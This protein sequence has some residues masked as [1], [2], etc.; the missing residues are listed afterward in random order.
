MPASYIYKVCTACSHSL[1]RAGLNSVADG[2]V[3]LRRASQ[4]VPEFGEHFLSVGAAATDASLYPSL[5]PGDYV[6]EPAVFQVSVMSYLYSVSGYQNQ[7]PLLA[8]CVTLVSSTN[9]YGNHH[10]SYCC[11]T[12]V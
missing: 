12:D 3:A 2:V 11:H 7:N 8:F 10:K 9:G 6:E 1:S 5:S 4:T